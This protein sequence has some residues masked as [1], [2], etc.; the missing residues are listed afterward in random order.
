MASKLSSEELIQL[1][2][3]LAG[4]PMPGPVAVISPETAERVVQLARW[5]KGM[6]NQVAWSPDGRLLAVASSLGV[7]IYN[8]ETLEEVRFIQSDAWVSSVAFSPDGQTLASG[9]WDTTVRLWRVAD[10]SLLRTLEG[11]TASVFS[12]AFSPGGYGRSG[13]T[14]LLASGSQDGTVRLWGVR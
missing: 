14:L 3:V 8:A 9:S 13:A 4:T 1:Q 2:P 6:V 11:H 12:V 5:G 10:G 7:Y